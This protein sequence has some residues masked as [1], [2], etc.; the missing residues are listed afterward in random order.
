MVSK[1]QTQGN[2]Q[3]EGTF[4]FDASEKLSGTSLRHENETATATDQSCDLYRG[5]V[6]ERKLLAASLVLQRGK[7]GQPAARLSSLTLSG[8]P[9]RP[10]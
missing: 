6:T 5:T 7:F 9:G 4:I 1:P 10:P 2:V 3:D 8:W